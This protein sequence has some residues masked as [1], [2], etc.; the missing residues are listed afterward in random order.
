MLNGKKI[1]FSSV[2]GAVS[3]LL[4]HRVIQKARRL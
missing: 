1:T 2:A 4:Q 3:G